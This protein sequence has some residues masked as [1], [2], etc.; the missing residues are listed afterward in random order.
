MDLVNTGRVK[1]VSNVNSLWEIF[2]WKLKFML[3]SYRKLM[4][5]ETFR[6]L[7]VY[8]EAVQGNL[9]NLS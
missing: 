5:R 9:Q 1:E 6:Q 2:F 8:M 4:S 3:F 7:A